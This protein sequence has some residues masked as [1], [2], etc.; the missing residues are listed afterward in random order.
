[1]LNT[2]KKLHKDYNN[3]MHKSDIKKQTD[4]IL[5]NLKGN[6]EIVDDTTSTGMV[7]VSNN[8]SVNEKVD[9]SIKDNLKAMMK[10]LKIPMKYFYKALY[11]YYLTMG[12]ASV[13]ALRLANPK[14]KDLYYQA[15][16]R[17]AR[18][19]EAEPTFQKLYGMIREEKLDFVSRIEPTEERIIDEAAN[20]LFDDSN[21]LK[22]LHKIQL[23]K[24]LLDHIA[25]HK[26]MRMKTDERLQ[27]NI[28]GGNTQVIINAPQPLENLSNEMR[29]KIVDANDTPEIVIEVEEVNAMG[30][31]E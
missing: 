20:W 11:I 22:P 4:E 27:V 29:A 28:N 8:L 30:G 1:M 16:Y 31:D 9:K 7:K 19:I 14:Y 21:D 5:A 2:V 3:D 15:C 23:Q 24:N 6:V 12:E 25:K 18:N 17:M 13:P 10:D 26:D